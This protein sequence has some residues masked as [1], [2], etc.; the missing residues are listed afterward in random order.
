[1]NDDVFKD[2][3]N[4]QL[5]DS[6]VRQTPVV[7]LG[8]FVVASINIGLFW[9]RVNH[10]FILAWAT[11]LL[12]T[13]LS[14]WLMKN[15][16]QRHQQR[17]TPGGWRRLFAVNSLFLGL[18]W[19]VWGLY[20]GVAIE[21]GGLG[22]SIIIITAAGLV[23]GAVASTS[24]SLVSYTCFSGPTLLPLSAL[25]LFTDQMETRGIGL[26]MVVFFAITFRQVQR[27]NSVLQESIINGLKLEK[28]KEETEKLAQELY[29]LSTVDA[30]TSVTNRRG[31]NEALNSEWARAKRLNTP[32]TLLLI[33]VDFFKTFNDSL[34][35]PAGDECLRLI[36]SMLTLHARRAGEVVAR[37]GGEEFAILLPNTTGKD[38]V[39][40]ADDI[41]VAAARLNIKHPASDVAEHVTVSIGVH[42]A[43]PRDV[44][45]SEE[46]IKLADHALYEAKAAGRNC[47][48]SAQQPASNTVES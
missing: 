14:R 27:I 18:A 1:M 22:L 20:V 13:G 2:K 41:C 25:L 39:K 9:Q 6:F 46:L 34:G 8:H 44:G 47:V 26:L 40:I 24:S 35:H 11:F 28:S 43:T 30:L 29:Q 4:Y 17:W 33:D 10:T 48:R 32:L 38:G 3:L 7:V 21:L 36:A 37:C 45:G 12:L 19:C 5:L 15:Q 23:A 31:F 16:Y 42:E